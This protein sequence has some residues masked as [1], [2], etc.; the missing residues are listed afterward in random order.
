MHHTLPAQIDLCSSSAVL[1]AS[2][3]P[4]DK[5]NVVASWTV[6]VNFVTSC[7]GNVAFTAAMAARV[8]SARVMFPLE[9]ALTSALRFSVT[10]K[11]TGG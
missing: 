6:A 5:S 7:S 10:A 4:E 8:K 9:R 2:A 3:E 11:A 1:F